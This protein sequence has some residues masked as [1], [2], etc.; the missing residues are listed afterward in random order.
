MKTRIKQITKTYDGIEITGYTAEVHVWQDSLS[1]YPARL[2][3]DWMGYT[4][5]MSKE[6]FTKEFGP[7][8]SLERAKKI[9]DSLLELVEND[10][11]E[12]ARQK[13]VE[14]SKKVKYIRYP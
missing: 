6:V 10:K 12:A 8:G 14:K 9:I 13:A 7:Y 3:L 2:K 1:W 4:D 5:S 11:Q